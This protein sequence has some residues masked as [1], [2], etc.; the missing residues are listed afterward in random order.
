M[1][2]KKSIEVEKIL[3]SKREREFI[4]YL[5][6]P[7]SQMFNV[8]SCFFIHANDILTYNWYIYH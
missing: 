8:F 5:F 1:L 4:R 2:L 7:N 3:K 6:L